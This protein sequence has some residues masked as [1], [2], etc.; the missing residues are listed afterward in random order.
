M[1]GSI[2]S[3]NSR[4]RS[5]VRKGLDSWDINSCLVVPTGVKVQLRR[6]G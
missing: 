4:M 6:I 5:L 3:R 1:S 2:S